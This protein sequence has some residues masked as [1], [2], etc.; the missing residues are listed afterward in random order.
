MSLNVAA[1]YATV[2]VTGAGQSVKDLQSVNAAAN[3]TMSTFGKLTKNAGQVAKGTVQVGQGLLRIGE[4]AA[5]G[6][7]A[8]ATASAKIAASFQADTEL[9][10]TQAGASQAEVDKMRL[11]IQAMVHEVG[12]SP[13]ELAKGLYHIESVGLRGAQALDVLKASALGAKVGLADME[14]VTNALTAVQYSGIKGAKDM[15]DAMAIL[16]GI[17]GVGNMHLQDLTDSFKSGILGT[18]ATFGVDLR[19]LGAAIATLTDAGVP[20][21]IAATRLNM[22]LSHMAAPVPKA[23]GVLKDLGISQFQ[24][25]N[26]LRGPDGIDAALLDIGKHLQAVGEMSKAGKLTPQGAAD[27]SAIFGGSRF[28]ATAMQ[29]LTNVMASSGDRIATKFDLITERSK[30]FGDNV[31]ATM[32]T[33]GFVWGQFRG[34]VDSVAI[35]FANGFLPSVARTLT[36]LD[37]M[38]LLHRGDIQKLGVDLGAAIDKIDWTGVEHGVSTF[39]GWLQKG[40]DVISKIPPEIDLAVAGFLAL[41]KVSG[42]L[43]G[44]GLGNIAGG[45]AKGGFNLVAGGISSVLSRLPVVGGAVDAVSD[46][47]A[48]RVHVTNWPIGFGAAGAA[49][50]AEGAGLAAGGF[51]IGGAAVGAGAVLAIIAGLVADKL[52]VDE[53]NKTPKSF[54]GPQNTTRDAR[55]DLINPGGYTGPPAAPTPRGTGGMSP[56]D[57]QAY[58]D[59]RNAADTERAGVNRAIGD[60]D[61]AALSWDTGSERI[62]T[63]FAAIAASFEGIAKSLVA[64]F[65]THIGGLSGIAGRSKAAGLHP[66]AA[67]LHHTFENDLLHKAGMIERSTQPVAQKIATLQ[68]LARHGDTKTK[69][70]IIAELKRLR[71]TLGTDLTSIKTQEATTRQKL[72]AAMNPKPVVIPFNVDG[73]ELAHALLKYG[74]ERQA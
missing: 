31:K 63:R 5:L 62:Q 53:L 17:V 48:A 27:L 37:K 15:T 42:G 30:T 18:A 64:A 74:P 51:A 41:N 69:A 23:I 58:N 36:K 21:N 55:G 72:I 70:A 26:D 7:A 33:A 40:W 9:I 14:S 4:W 67:A 52:L 11:S 2:G 47:T 68:E 49:G 43:L 56:D 45:L 57:R 59:A 25:A 38:L 60:F 1:L 28:G 73:Q 46:L 66:S 34:D 20:A 10:H 16:D 22:T 3:S 71:S 35:D 6:A 24:L 39:V 65:L 12:T 19:S 29:L 13:D 32:Q 50:A 8:A 54:T 44:S 61:K